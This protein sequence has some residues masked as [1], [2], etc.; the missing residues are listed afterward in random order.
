MNFNKIT[1]RNNIQICYDI[2]GKDLN[3]EPIILIS[4]AG[5]QMLGWPDEFCKLLADRNNK[6]IRFDNRDMGESTNLTYLP[7]PSPL[8]FTLKQKFGFNIKPPYT[9]ENLA[10]DVVQLMDALGIEKAH[11]VGISLGSMIAQIVAYTYNDRVASL[12]CIATQARNS[13]HSMPKISTV[14]KIM[15]SPKPG[16][17][18]YIDWSINLVKAVG[19]SMAHDSNEYIG[20]IAGKMFDRGINNKGMNRQV[21][22]V[23][24][25][26]D[27]RKFLSGI[28]VPTL[29]IH[30][31]ED[32]LIDSEA[33]EEVAKSIPGSEF[34]I[35]EKM[36]HGIL[37]PAWS[38]LVD[39]IDNHIKSSSQK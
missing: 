29:I 5:L 13:A 31:A 19:G 7:S 32:P 34:R 36:G 4:G 21:C 3:T 10:E 27:R 25:S 30:G 26:N 39:L 14:L 38:Q 15:K 37:K 28:S 17:Q 8:W 22:A 24:A 23:Y 16:K 18:G 20:E 2:L 11:L 1:L 6:I 12:V 33:G 35:I 9:L